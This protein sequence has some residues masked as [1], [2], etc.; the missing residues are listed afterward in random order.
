MK[1]VC[2]SGS[3]LFTPAESV[4]NAE[5]VGAFN[6]Y[7]ALYN[8][9]HEAEIEA[10]AVQ[11]LAPSSDE[12][13]VKASGIKARYTMDKAGVIDPAIMRP[14]IRKRGEDEP[15]LLVEM[16]LAAAREAL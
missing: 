12:F 6:H 3:G 8:A 11:A 16:G 5:L 7:V 15:A 10:G 9:E 1:P 4:S 2:I 13:I 14:L